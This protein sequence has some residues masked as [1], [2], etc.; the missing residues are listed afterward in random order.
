MG[1]DFVF[2]RI[3]MV[4][5][6]MIGVIHIA[7][8]MFF[9]RFNFEAKTSFRLTCLAGDTRQG[10]S[11]PEAFVGHVYRVLPGQLGMGLPA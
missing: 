2:M 8:K 5:A 4:G 7:S 11:R 6:T 9:V 3:W 10:A 1:V